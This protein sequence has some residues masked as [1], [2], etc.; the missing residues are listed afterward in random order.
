MN[1]DEIL[2]SICCL[3]YNHEK[4]IREALNGFLMQKTNFD[5]EILIHDDASTD[6]TQKIIQE[7][8]N[9]HPALFKPIFQKENQRSKLGGGMN[10]RF[11]HPR[12]L[13]KYIAHCEGDDYWTDPYKLQK[14]VDFLEANEEYSICAHAVNKISENG[15]FISVFSKP[16]SYSRIDFLHNHSISNLSTVFRNNLENLPSTKNVYNGDTFLFNFLLEGKKAF[17]MEDIMGVHRTHS[18]GVW[19]SKDVVFKLKQSMNTKILIQQRMILTDEENEA[20]NQKIQE[21]KNWLA[22]YENPYKNLIQ[23]KLPLKLFMEN[24]WN[25]FKS[26][27]YKLKENSF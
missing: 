27:L 21:Y 22:Y 20:F 7:Y 12:A 6:N 24:K 16:G 14:Q 11:N 8:M 18:G 17:V 19:S 10:A 1:S 4:Y 5:F 13:G 26:K 3:T 9:E 25:E 23:G 2:V 15:E